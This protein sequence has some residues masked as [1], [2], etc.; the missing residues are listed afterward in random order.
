[1]NEAKV[2]EVLDYIYEK[3][4]YINHLGYFEADESAKER[5]LE[6]IEV[7]IEELTDDDL[8]EEQLTMTSL[9]T[10]LMVVQT[11]MLVMIY[12]VLV[13]K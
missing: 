11:G 3:V 7:A 12:L 6:E 4:H 5:V 8:G 13:L 9:E 10:F 2:R 1:M